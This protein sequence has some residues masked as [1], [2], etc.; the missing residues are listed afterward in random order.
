M[1]S[2][3][4]TAMRWPTASRTARATSRGKRARFSSEPPQWSVRR[5]RLRREE[6]A[7]QVAV[8]EV[9]LDR[10]EARP[11]RRTRARAREVAGDARDLG[12]GDGARAAHG[13][14]AED[15]RRR[16]AAAPGARRDRARVADLRRD[17]GALGVHGVGEARR[18]GI[19]A[20]VRIISF[21]APW[22]SSETAQYATVV[23]PTPPAAMRRW[24]SIRRSLDHVLG[25]HALEGRGLDR[26]GCA[27]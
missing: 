3:A 17:R 16:E 13:E 8:A 1:L 23:M 9:E 22:P 21:G 26:R 6:L 5:L 25:R 11:P 2:F 4:S 27:A 12:L 10:V 24:N 15:R 19:A 18:P 7:E 14:R 20:S